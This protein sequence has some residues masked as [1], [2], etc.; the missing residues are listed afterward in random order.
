MRSQAYSRMK[1]LTSVYGKIND[2][3][4]ILREYRVTCPPNTNRK[5]VIFLSYLIR[6]FTIPTDPKA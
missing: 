4:M 3:A 5:M 2:I 1:D 6:E